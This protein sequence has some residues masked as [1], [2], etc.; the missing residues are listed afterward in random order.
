MFNRVTLSVALLASAG[1]AAAVTIP[2][3]IDLE[4]NGTGSFTNS[5][6]VTVDFTGSAVT[7]GFKFS[8]PPTALAG[9]KP[10][11]LFLDSGA[12][13]V[14]EII[15]TKANIT[16]LTSDFTAPEKNTLTI[17]KTGDDTK[18]VPVG[19]GSAIQPGSISSIDLTYHFTD[20]PGPEA[21]LVLVGM[22]VSLIRR[23]RNQR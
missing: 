10:G 15:W 3:T 21:A 5:L 7:G 19:P 22:G 17:A 23:K 20:T 6:D 9:G 1:Y 2:R 14:D 13:I 4:S 11:T 18:Y 8:P 12:T 16:F